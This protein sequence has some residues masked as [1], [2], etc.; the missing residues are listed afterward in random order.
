[1]LNTHTFV[2][3]GDVKS[4][5]RVLVWAR[6]YLMREQGGVKRPY[7]PQTVCPF[8][9]TSIKANSLYMVFHNELNGQ[10]PAAIADVILKYVN[11]FKEAPPFAR[12]EQILKA[13]LIVFPNIEERFLT[14]LDECHRMIKPKIVNFGLMIGQFHPM[15][16]ERAIHNPQWN[17]ISQSPVPLVAMRHMTIH[18]I[19]FLHDNEEAFRAYESRFGCRFAER[20][21]SLLPYQKH[22]ITYYERAK[23]AYAYARLE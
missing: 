7:P 16:R 10:D 19:M 17:A 12:H 11:P 2:S 23:S 5:K 15:C 22:L 6:N 1:M 8:V 14:V 9:E 4:A 3:P 18:D 13:L 21:E 20:G